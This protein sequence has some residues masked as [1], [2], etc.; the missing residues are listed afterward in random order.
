[1]R[2][3]E[4]SSHPLVQFIKRKRNMTSLQ[5][6]EYFKRDLL[7]KSFQVIGKISDIGSGGLRLNV[8]VSEYEPEYS[9]EQQYF[10]AY[11]D[12]DSE[13]NSQMIHFS[14]DELVVCIGTLKSIDY[15]FDLVSI[16]KYNGRTYEDIKHENKT[17][18]KT[19]WSLIGLFSVFFA[20]IFFSSG[21]SWWILGII[22]GI[23][24][25]YSFDHGF[26]DV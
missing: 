25:L 12:F 4:S 16:S 15:R 10:I 6:E 5:K 19:K 9:S 7:N 3:I 21:G 14:K 24:A 2:Y 17:N 23:F 26:S 8:E 1:M 20:F 13:F 18:R 11:L 22:A